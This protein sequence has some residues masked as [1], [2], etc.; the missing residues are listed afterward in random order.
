MCTWK[1]RFRWEAGLKCILRNISVQSLLF[2]LFL[3]RPSAYKKRF[4]CL[5]SPSNPPSQTFHP[6]YP[7]FRL[8]SQNLS[9]GN[10]V[11][12]DFSTN[13]PSHPPLLPTVDFILTPSLSSLIFWPPFPLCEFR[14]S[15]PPF[16][17]RIHSS[18]F[19]SST[20]FTSISCPHPFPS[21]PSSTPS[22]PLSYHLYTSSLHLS[23][24]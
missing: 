12:N 18:T 11:R 3:G 13:R 17:Y 16:L 10:L 8:L 20:T 14:L 15:P 4:I 23:I 19:P 1:I 2:I 24:L 22:L 7:F 5:L 6:Y 9:S 21:F